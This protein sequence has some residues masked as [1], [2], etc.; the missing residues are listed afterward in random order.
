MAWDVDERKPIYPQLMEKIMK[1]IIQGEYP[2]G[3]RIPSVRD[4]AAEAAVN[5]NTMQK[6]MTELERLELI[7]T[8]RGM[9]RTVTENEEKILFMKKE[10]AEKTIKECVESLKELGYSLEDIEKLISVYTGKN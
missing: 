2:L 3:E 6:A 8:Q 4:L 7:V 10:I 9:G 5:P 1:R